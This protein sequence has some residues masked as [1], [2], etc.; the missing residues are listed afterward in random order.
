MDTA[1]SETDHGVSVLDSIAED[2][3]AIYR[4]F[5]KRLVSLR[6]MSLY[7]SFGIPRY[8]LE[9]RA[10]NQQFVRQLDV[11][12]TTMAIERTEVVDRRGQKR[13]ITYSDYVNIGGGLLMARKIDLIRHGSDGY[14]LKIKV[15]SNTIDQK[16]AN[17]L[18][19]VD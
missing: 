2:I 9:E 1:R 14:W 17:E 12:A 18:F 13:T 16:L 8:R 3:R 7:E 10:P 11:F 19:V 6:R 4:L 15:Q 5:P